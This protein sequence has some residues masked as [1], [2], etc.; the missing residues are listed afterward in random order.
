MKC[1]V[2]IQKYFFIYYCFRIGYLLIRVAIRFGTEANFGQASK[3]SIKDVVG[4]A[5]TG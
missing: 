5:T 3:S 1:H 4:F 2:E